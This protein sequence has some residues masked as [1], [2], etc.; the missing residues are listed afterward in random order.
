MLAVI[1]ALVGMLVWLLTWRVVDEDRF[2]GVAVATVQ[3]P[4][5]VD[6]VVR[7]VDDAVRSA[8]ADR[9]RD[10]PP[11]LDAVL[12]TAVTR[13][14]ASPRLGELLDGTLRRVHRRFVEDPTEPVVIDLGALRD[15]VAAR[16]READ[17]ALASLIPSDRD[18]GTIEWVPSETYPELGDLASAVDRLQRLPWIALALTLVLTG[19]G[20]LLSGTR[21]RFCRRMGV[22][23]LCLAVLALLVGLVAP[24][25]SGSIAGD[26][27][28]EVV[29]GAVLGGWW[30]MTLLLGLAGAGLLAY[31]LLGSD[32]RRIRST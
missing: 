11:R 4:A 23:A 30:W 14:V 32:P 29:A 26:E 7:T 16:V 31:G 17:P 15:D 3:S 10:V 19:A 21:R 27:I 18:L 5:G 20:F 25:V 9:G 28:V 22:A 8:A 24:P 1:L 6:L 12:D 13:V 2:A